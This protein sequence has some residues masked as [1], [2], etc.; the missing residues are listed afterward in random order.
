MERYTWEEDSFH[1]LNEERKKGAQSNCVKL[2]GSLNCIRKS[3]RIT[4]FPRG[5][6]AFVFHRQVV[7]FKEN[8][9]R[10]GHQEIWKKDICQGR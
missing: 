4:M 1:S 10:I 6:L 9:L 8:G 5:S 2:I 3:N 7:L